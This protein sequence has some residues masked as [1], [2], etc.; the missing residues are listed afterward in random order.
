[1][2]PSGIS[3]STQRLFHGPPHFH[4]P[5]FSL[6]LILIAIFQANHVLPDPRLLKYEQ[7]YKIFLGKDNF[8]PPP[9]RGKGQRRQ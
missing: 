3:P 5:K 9:E 6:L 1:M 2:D 4:G 7:I 8:F